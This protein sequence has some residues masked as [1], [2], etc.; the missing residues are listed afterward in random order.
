MR[1]NQVRIPFKL[2]SQFEE[3]NLQNAGESTRF[4][5][6]EFYSGGNGDFTGRVKVKLGINNEGAFIGEA[7][8]RKER[9]FNS[10]YFLGGKITRT[11]PQFLSKILLRQE[12][13]LPHID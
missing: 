7:G 13:A 10:F 6:L 3:G 9:R 8:E 2:L 1:L 5:Y 12:R 11:R 4:G